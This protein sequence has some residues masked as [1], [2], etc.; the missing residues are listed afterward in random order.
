MGR[1]NSGFIEGTCLLAALKSSVD[2]LMV[3][4]PAL[5]CLN[6][7]FI[8]VALTAPIGPFPRWAFYHS[9]MTPRIIARSNYENK[10]R[11]KLY[12]TDITPNYKPRLKVM[13]FNCINYNINTVCILICTLILIQY[14]YRMYVLIQY[15]NTASSVVT[16]FIDYCDWVLCCFQK[17]SSRQ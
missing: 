17:S 15:V 9:R 10:F 12:C 11:A 4:F 13:L 3:T 16:A 5:I 6:T 8:T 14:W 7:S 1:W 2:V